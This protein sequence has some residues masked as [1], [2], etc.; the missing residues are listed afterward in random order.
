MPVIAGILPW[1]S[2]LLVSPFSSTHAA[3]SCSPVTAVLTCYCT[4]SNPLSAAAVAAAVAAAL[5][6]QLHW[7][8]WNGR[9]IGEYRVLQR[10]VY[11]CSIISCNIVLAVVSVPCRGTSPFL[12]HFSSIS[13]SCETMHSPQPRGRLYAADLGPKRL[14]GY[15]RTIHGTCVGPISLLL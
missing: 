10:Y 1:L 12:A 9:D 8:R 4:G 3:V 15:L 5:L 6:Q 11:T 7:S 2:V 13:P 14:Q